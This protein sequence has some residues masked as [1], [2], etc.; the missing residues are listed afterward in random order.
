MCMCANYSVWRHC[1]CTFTLP[2]LLSKSV[3]VPSLGVQVCTPMAGGVGSGTRR[4]VA[5][6]TAITQCP[7]GA[8]CHMHVRFEELGLGS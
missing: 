3:A 5:T 7:K 2:A 1:E 4:H 8:E 6:A